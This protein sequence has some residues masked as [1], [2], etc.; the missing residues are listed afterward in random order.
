MQDPPLPKMAQPDLNFSLSLLF[1][2]LNQVGPDLQNAILETVRPQ[3]PQDAVK[4]S[5]VIHHLRV[6]RHRWIAYDRASL[7]EK[8]GLLTENLAQQY[9]LTPW[10]R[11]SIHEGAD[12]LEYFLRRYASMCLRELLSDRL[13]NWT[14]GQYRPGDSSDF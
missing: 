4:S 9:P 3:T 14:E 8:P 7:S 13:E 10:T 6:L 5:A 11:P 2:S 1:E 12:V